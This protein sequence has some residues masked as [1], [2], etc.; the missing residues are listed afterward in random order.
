MNTYYV[1]KNEN[2]RYLKSAKGGWCDNIKGAAYGTKAQMQDLIDQKKNSPYQMTLESI[3][4]NISG[5]MA[6]LAKVREIEGHEYTYDVV[7]QDDNDSNSKGFNSSL[8]ECK[9]YVQTYNGTNESYFGDYKGGIVQIVCN[10]TEEV[11]YEEEIK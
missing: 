4:E 1:I 11:V 5:W 6:K 8:E 9:D 10:Q 2:G 7:F 3:G